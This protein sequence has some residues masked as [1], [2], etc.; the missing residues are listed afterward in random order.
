VAEVASADL[1]NA[2]AMREEYESHPP[3]HYEGHG[4]GTNEDRSAW[5]DKALD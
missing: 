4:L 3:P 1:L 2:R 5:L